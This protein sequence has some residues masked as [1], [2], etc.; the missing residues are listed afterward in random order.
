MPKLPFGL[1]L[2]GVSPAADGVE[3]HVEGKDTV[4]GA[5]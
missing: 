5:A 4:L 1:T 3:V 2:S